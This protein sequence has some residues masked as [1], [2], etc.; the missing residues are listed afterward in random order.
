MQ[1]H[2][3]LRMAKLTWNPLKRSMLHGHGPGPRPHKKAKRT[4]LATFTGRVIAMEATSTAVTGEKRKR[5]HEA[6]L[7]PGVDGH[8]IWGFPNS[9]VTKLRYCDYLT[10]SSTTGVRALNVFAANG[11]YDPDITGTGHQPMYHDTYAAIYDQYTVIGSKITVH[12]APASSKPWIV[13]INGDDDST[14]TTVVATL[15]EQNNA[16]ST[17][18]AANGGPVA[19]ITNSYAPIRDVGVDVKDDGFSQTDQGSN[20]TEL[21]CYAVWGAPADGSSTDTCF[22]KVEIEYTVKFAELKTPSQN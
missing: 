20:P 2:S 15:L 4:H 13:G 10:L 6:H 17:M 5:E 8:R 16:F 9:I 21:F 18:A 14:S 3:K 22:I 12:F 11:I 7:I 19:C 1:I